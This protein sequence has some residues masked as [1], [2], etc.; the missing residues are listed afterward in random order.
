VTVLAASPTLT[1]SEQHLA[2]EG[3]DHAYTI[4]STDG[5]TTYTPLANANTADGPLGPALNGDSDAFATQ[6]FDLTP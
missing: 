6:T 3:Y 1:F 4:V 2:E 5:G